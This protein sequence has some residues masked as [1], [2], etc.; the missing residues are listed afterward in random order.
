MHTHTHSLTSGAINAMVP[1]SCPWNSPA[2]VP[3]D[4]NLA[5]APKSAILSLCPVLSISR[6]APTIK[7]NKK[8]WW[9]PRG[10]SRGG[11]SIS[12]VT[13]LHITPNT[14]HTFQWDPPTFPLTTA[15]KHALLNAASMSLDMACTQFKASGPKGHRE[16]KTSLGSG[17]ST[18]HRYSL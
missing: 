6:L 15:G 2:P 13:A 18:M 16:T 7:H 11:K 9:L 5:A 3:F 14:T 17:S 1:R 10:N 4:A 8:C 12:L